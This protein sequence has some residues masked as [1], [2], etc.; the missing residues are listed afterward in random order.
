MSKRRAIALAGLSLIVGV[1]ALGV[2][3]LSVRAAPVAI[4]D[5]AFDVAADRVDIDAETG[6]AVL[7]G[8]VTARFGDVEV[9][10]D[11]VELRYD[12]APRVSWARGT[13]SVSA[14]L[15]GIDATASTVEF[16]A[17]SHSVVLAG[18]VRLTHGKGWV[19]ADR[20]TMDLSTNKVSLQ[21]VKGSIP[22]QAAGSFAHP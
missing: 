12:R 21:E 18:S 4:D 1:A 9:R 15:K 20:A 8:A 13:G 5:Q 3:T 11:K 7:E 2:S 19:T 10:A 6:A 16:E 17:K 22:V 14:R